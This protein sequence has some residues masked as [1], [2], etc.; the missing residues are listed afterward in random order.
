MLDFGITL[1]LDMS[2][3]RSVALTR[4]AERAGFSYGKG[5]GIRSRDSLFPRGYQ[6]RGTRPVEAEGADECLH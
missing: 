5:G 2:H 1:K 4:Q 3:Q 6:E